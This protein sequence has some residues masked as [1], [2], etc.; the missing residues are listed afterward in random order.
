MST[1]LSGFVLLSIR[2]SLLL[3]RAEDLLFVIT[4]VYVLIFAGRKGCRQHH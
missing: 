2:L 4:L 1:L 3:F